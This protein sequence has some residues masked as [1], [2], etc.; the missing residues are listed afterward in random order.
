MNEI[1]RMQQLA[2]INEIKVNKPVN[3]KEILL[4]II[5]EGGYLLERLIDFNNIKSF[6]GNGD[7]PDTSFKFD[8]KSH[9]GVDTEDLR[10]TK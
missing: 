4:G 1:K 3:K 8:S 9:P 5:S 10:E 7:I 2:G 6:L